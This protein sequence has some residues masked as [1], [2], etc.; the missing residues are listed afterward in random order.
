MKKDME[1]KE[2]SINEMMEDI[3]DLMV[4][5][6]L[7]HDIVANKPDEKRWLTGLAEKYGIS[8]DNKEDLAEI[9]S[10]FVER[11]KRRKDRKGH[12]PIRLRGES[13]NG[14]F[15]YKVEAFSFA[16]LYHKCISI[17]AISILDNEDP[18]E[19]A[20]MV[21]YQKTDED[22]LDEDGHFSESLFQTWRKG[23]KLTDEEIWILLLT[24]NGKAHSRNVERWDIKNECWSL[25]YN[26]DFDEEGA[27]IDDTEER[28]GEAYE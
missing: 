14:C 8:L 18:Y 24:E 4:A 1:C 25:L 9:H 6:L 27:F 3:Q 10:H 21:K 28:T 11:M 26:G 19:T 5:I 22:F 20:L 13:A 12:A 2:N 23:K 17:N 15:R 7:H 16:E